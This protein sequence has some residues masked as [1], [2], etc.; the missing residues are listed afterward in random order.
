MYF[1]ADTTPIE[2]NNPLYTGVVRDLDLDPL[3]ANHHMHDEYAMASEIFDDAMDSLRATV[4]A[5]YL[6]G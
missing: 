2:D 5:A 3:D 6:Q 1:T 4:R